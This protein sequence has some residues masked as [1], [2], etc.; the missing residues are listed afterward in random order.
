MAYTPELTYEAS[1]TLRRLA[2]AL[3]VPMTKAIDIVM[4]IIPLIVDRDKVCEGCRDKSRC[5]DC[6]FSPQNHKACN[7]LLR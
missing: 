6:S 4:N 5:A 1:C 7:K 2:W 3:H